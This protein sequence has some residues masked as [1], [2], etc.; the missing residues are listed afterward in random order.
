MKMSIN[1]S[2]APSLGSKEAF[3]GKI[4]RLNAPLNTGVLAD[5]APDYC[6][7]SPNYCFHVTG[8]KIPCV[9]AHVCVHLA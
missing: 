4:F 8:S 1:C 5:I 6:E 7:M 2:L 9:S 3:K